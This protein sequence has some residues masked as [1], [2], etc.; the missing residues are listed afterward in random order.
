[1]ILLNDGSNECSILSPK[2]SNI[3]RES[4]EHQ[5]NTNQ[6]DYDYDYQVMADDLDAAMDDNFF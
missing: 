5:N 6:P 4:M 2:D 1:M 3:Y